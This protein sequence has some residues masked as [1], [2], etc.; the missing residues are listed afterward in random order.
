MV[1]EHDR[2]HAA[3]QAYFQQ[4]DPTME[5]RVAQ[6]PRPM[7]EAF[8]CVAHPFRFPPGT[9]LG[10]FQRQCALRAG[11]P[12]EIMSAGNAQELR[13]FLDYANRY[14]HV[15][16]AAYATELINDAELTDFTYRTLAFIPRP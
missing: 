16:N 2:R 6:S 13:A 12:R 1:T 7:L 10:P 3:A 15:P 8:C 11:T 4:A 9:L 14:H 5:R